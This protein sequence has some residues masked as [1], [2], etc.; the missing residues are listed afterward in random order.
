MDIDGLRRD[1]E[2]LLRS[3]SR[4]SGLAAAIRTRADACDVRSVIDQMDAGLMVHLAIEDV[5]VYPQLMRHPDAQ[6]KVMASET[7]AEMGVI[8]G[9]W[10]SYRDLWDV[11]RILA[12]TARFATATDAVVQALAM[13]IAMENDVLYPAALA[14]VADPD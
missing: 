8:K 11:D 2:V 1:H 12:D 14:A 7:F 10:V 13:R 5:D 4:L 9:A 6:L 3:A